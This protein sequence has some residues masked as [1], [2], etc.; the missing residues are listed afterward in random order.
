MSDRKFF[1]TVFTVEVLTEDEPMPGCDLDALNYE[2]TEGHAS[3]RITREDPVEL[4]AADA[5]RRLIVHG[6]DPEFFRLS[7][8]GRVLD[9]RE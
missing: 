9:E 4:T 2:I 5:A 3:G 8:D 7:D 6:S 1:K